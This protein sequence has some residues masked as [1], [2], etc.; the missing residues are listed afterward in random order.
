[1]GNVRQRSLRV[2]ILLRTEVKVQGSRASSAR[3]PTLQDVAKAAGVSRALVSIVIRGVPGA[4]EE[5]RARVLEIAQELGYRPDVRARQL[6]RAST[7]LIGVTYLVSSMHHADLLAPIYEAAEAA[8]YEVILSGR[9]RHHDERHAVNTL[10]GY[11]CDALILLGPPLS[12]PAL[13][14]LASTLPVVIVGGR[15]VH[16]VGPIDS[17]RT[18][19]NVGLRLAVEHLVGLGHERIAH[20]DGGRGIRASDRR[21]GY[22]AAMT[23]AG[24]QSSI[25]VVEGDETAEAGCRAGADLLT[26]DP[27]PTAIIAYNDDCAWGVMRAVADAGLTVPRDISVVGYDASQ[28]SRLGPHELTT[29]RQDADAMGRLSV[30]RAVGRIQGLEPAEPNVVLL[31][32]LVIGETAGPA[33]SSAP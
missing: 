5:T 27:R 24:I 20:V 11:R 29:V 7:R 33:A 8:G 3:K 22:R 25:R 26:L 2:N 15:M 31:P 9:T 13:N 18:D 10:L 32:T 1:M 23:R 28:L 6:A 16:P 30:E 12:E 19:D 21:R 4:S 17:I 14:D